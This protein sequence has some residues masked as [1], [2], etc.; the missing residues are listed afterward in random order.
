MI[1]LL[2]EI[3]IGEQDPKTGKWLARCVRDDCDN[4]TFLVR[5]KGANIKAHCRSAVSSPAVATYYPCAHRGLEVLRVEAGHS[6]GCIGQNVY[7]C[8][9]HQECTI[10]KFT[11]NPAKQLPMCKTCEQRQEPLES[12]AVDSGAVT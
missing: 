7:A 3:E 12:G 10:G 1:K 8:A 6:C 5:N 4:P 11:N 9:M 2:C